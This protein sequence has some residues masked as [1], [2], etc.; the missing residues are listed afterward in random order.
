MCAIVFATFTNPEDTHAGVFS[1]VN[2][3]IGGE[4]ADAS[5]LSSAREP[6]SQ[7]LGL[8]QAALN[9]NPVASIP[10]LSIVDESALETSHGPAGTAKEVAERANADTISVYVVRNG[11]TLS[12][13]AK[14]FGVSANTILWANDL[15]NARDIHPGDELII[16]PVSGV[17]YTVAKGDTLKGIAAKYHGDVA[18]IL[19][20]NDLPDN[21]LPKIGDEIIIPDGEINAPALPAP[22]GRLAASSAQYGNLAGYFIRP[23]SGIKSQGLHGKYRSGVDIAAP[24]GTPVYAAA[25]GTVLIAKSG[26]W[27][28]GYGSYIVVEH[29][30]GIQTLYGHLSQVLVSPGDRVAQGALI[31]KMGATG[32]ST[33]SHLHFELW[34]GVRNWNPFN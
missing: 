21:Y 1:F 7:T 12:A 34:G 31:A 25:G 3:L 13:I 30:N 6:N 10:A 2:K 32:K 29:P 19:A 11:D 9:T 28:A 22:S 26:G 27:N 8:L 16:L 33:G 15:D 20:F 5:S 24:L 23:A 4:E 17:Q 18:D 14:M